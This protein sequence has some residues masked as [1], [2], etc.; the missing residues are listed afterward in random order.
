LA[1]GAA[2]QIFLDLPAGSPLLQATLGDDALEI[3]NK[4]V[5]L[6]E[7]TSPVRVSVDLADAGLRQA[8][9]R[10]LEATGM[11][12][13]VSER[14]ELIVCDGGGA[15][16][17]GRGARGDG[18]EGGDQSSLIPHPSSL[19]PP[20]DAWRLEVLGA[21]DAT[22]YTG[23]FVVD[24]THPLAQGLSLDGAIWSASPQA[25]LGG[26]AIVTAGN[27]TLLTDREDGAG[28]H[29]LQMSFAPELSNLQDV[30][31][32]PILFANLLRWRR[33]AA[34]GAQSPNVRLGQNAVFT[35]PE[36]AKQVEVLAP[37]GPAWTLDVHTRRVEV[38]ADRVGLYT[39]KTPGAAYQFSCNAV[40]RD[41]SDL[42]HAETGRWGD[43]SGSPVH[44][45]RQ[46]S[47]RWVFLLL[48]LACLAAHLGVVRVR[49][50]GE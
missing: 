44:M 31:D 23:P 20:L 39:V 26:A 36:D 35:L 37:S 6:P 19:A 2:R 16:D 38:P 18:Q 24:R 27:V 29:R 9:V 5:L 14:P 32:W 45:D 22:A 4:V 30:P 12:L 11:A 21:K 15:R 48:A 13:Q 40:S 47:I 46:I 8:V 33:G 17:E 34:A 25:A 3:D 28:R 10:V 1:A 50:P 7:S 49:G 41:E 42:S 43:W